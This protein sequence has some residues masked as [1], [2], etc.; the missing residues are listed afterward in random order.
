MNARII[1][2]VASKDGRTRGAV[3][4]FAA[5]LA[6]LSASCCVLPIVL[7]IVGLGGPWLAVLGPIVAYRS[8]VL[9]AVG[10]VL[11]WAWCRLIRPSRCGVRKPGAVVL[12]GFA[13]LSVV[14]AASSPVWEEDAARMMMNVRSATR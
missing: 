1:S 13:S 12:A 2:I 7:S 6:L 9:V 14:V 11:L 3:V 10:L 8:A 4:G 5:L